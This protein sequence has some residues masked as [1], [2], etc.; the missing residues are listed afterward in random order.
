[1]KLDPR[2]ITAKDYIMYILSGVIINN[3][4]G[5]LWAVTALQA[6]GLITVTSVPLFFSGWTIGNGVPSL[7]FGIILLKALSPMI[8][9]HKAFCKGWLA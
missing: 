3:I 7:I 1:M 2:L 4:L 9:K 6:I 5:A 8:V